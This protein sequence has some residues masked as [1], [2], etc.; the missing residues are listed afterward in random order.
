M[1]CAIRV[2]KAGQLVRSW[3]RLAYL[4][5]GFIVCDINRK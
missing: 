3:L 4:I 2:D 5:T 1:K